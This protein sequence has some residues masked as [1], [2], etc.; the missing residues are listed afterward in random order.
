M[1]FY[2][3]FQLL[4]VIASS[5]TSNICLGP[6]NFQSTCHFC[7]W[8]YYDEYNFQKQLSNWT[9]PLTINFSNCKKQN[10]NLIGT[11]KVLITNSI[12]DSSFLSNF[13][14]NYPDF[15]EA[16]L[17]ETDYL[18]KNNVTE[19]YIYLVSGTHYYYQY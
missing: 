2:F 14:A 12:V 1:F 15:I 19:E 11:R 17:Y 3:I 8:G 10:M 5:Q 6:D 9:S 16:L 18:L 4:L 7:G 13:D